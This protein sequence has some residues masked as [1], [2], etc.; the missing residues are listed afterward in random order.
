M[1]PTLMAASLLY[2]P[3]AKAEIAP[4]VEADAVYTADYV[5]PLSGASAQKAAVLDNLLI[6]LNVDLQRFANLS[7]GKFYVSLLSNSGGTPNDHVGTL[8]GVDNIEVAEQGARL[9]QAWLEADL[10]HINWRAGLY[11]LNSEF[12]SN[13]SAGLLLAPPFGIGSEL[14]ATGVNGPAIFPSTALALRARLPISDDV[15]A[16][17]AIVNAHAGVPGDPSGVDLS[18]DNGELLIAELTHNGSLHASVGAWEY[19]DRQPDIRSA[20]VR[21]HA[22]GA[23]LTLEQRVWGDETS[24]ANA[25]AFARVGISDGDTTPYSGGWQAGLLFAHVLAQRPDSQASVGIYQG[26]L[27]AKERAN[28][29]D[30]GVRASTA[31]S[32]VEVTFSDQLTPWLRV[33]PDLQLVL[34]PAGDRDR[35]DAWVAGLRIAISPF[36]H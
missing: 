16:K 7:G 15:D 14:A 25:T 1:T 23:Y 31:E 10:V 12:Y 36:A 20:S 3:G 28:M 26:R 18:F 29:A 5:T 33:Q 24:V 11:D 22:Y 6:S 8:Q 13:E 21:Q 17:F 19:T 34:D 9:F 2:A 35:K 4:G 27:D 30:A 32:G